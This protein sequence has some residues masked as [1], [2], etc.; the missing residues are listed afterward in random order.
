MGEAPQHAS[1][2]WK[3]SKNPTYSSITSAR[4]QDFHRLVSSMMQ[5]RESIARDEYADIAA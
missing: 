1:K 4:A 5:A 3:A 2:T